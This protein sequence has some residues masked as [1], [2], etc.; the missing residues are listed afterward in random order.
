VR[1]LAVEEAK[2]IYEINGA[3][4]SLAAARAAAGMTESRA[5]ELRAVVD[6][7]DGAMSRDDRE[8]FFQANSEFHAAILACGGNREAQAP[9]DQVTRKL[10]LLR[11]RSFEQTG[12]MQDANREHAALPEAILAGNAG[13]ARDLAEAHARL[14][15][16]RLL[17]AIGHAA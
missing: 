16:K 4:F 5:A 8:A 17:D 12:H 6:A 3:L 14:G 1:T 10:Q 13:R 9:C 15:R 7:M 2:E 11:R